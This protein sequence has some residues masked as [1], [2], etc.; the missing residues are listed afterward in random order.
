MKFLAAMCILIGFVN[1]FYLGINLV[2]DCERT[3][4]KFTICSLT[5]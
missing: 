1:G 4:D 5:K 3:N 2:K